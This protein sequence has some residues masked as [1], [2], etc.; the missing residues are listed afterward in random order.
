MNAEA[1][2]LHGGQVKDCVNH[3]YLEIGPTHRS[4]RGAEEYLLQL[5]RP[6]RFPRLTKG[7]LR[8]LSL[9]VTMDYGKGPFTRTLAIL[10]REAREK[11]A[12]RFL[13][14]YALGEDRYFPDVVDLSFPSIPGVR[15]VLTSSRFRSEVEFDV[16]SR[17][18]PVENEL[19]SDVLYF[20]KQA[21]LASSLERF[22]ECTGY[23]RAYT[24]ACTSLVEAFLHRVILVESIEGFDPAKIQ[25]LQT[26]MAMELLLQKWVDA[27]C[28]QPLKTL[29][30]TPAWDHFKVLRRERNK[31]VHPGEAVW[32]RNM[33]D[34]AFH[35]NLVREGVGALLR[36]L[37]RMQG[38]D[39]VEFI[40]RLETAPLVR[41]VEC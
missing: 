6:P 41:Y 38:L 19:C 35:L 39:T 5:L 17:Y 31:I 1:K 25:E 14:T 9:E 40:E 29:K 37:R 28:T 8:N 13:R 20:R 32:C 30:A 10:R 33:K 27:F 34:I 2:P 22:E 36:K 3:R 7:Q 16:A 15:A 24:L 4:Q 11:G 23:V 21:C 12:V 26:P 18:G